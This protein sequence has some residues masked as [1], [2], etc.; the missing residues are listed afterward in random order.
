M[1]KFI[2]QKH[3]VSERPGGYTAVRGK[4]K[5]RKTRRRRQEENLSEKNA[6]KCGFVVVLRQEKFFQKAVLRKPGSN[7]VELSPSFKEVAF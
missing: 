7:S 6:E 3:P 1:C 5:E 2:T 4:K